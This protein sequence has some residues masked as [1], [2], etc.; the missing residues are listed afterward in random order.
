MSLTAEKIA[1]IVDQR[2]VSVRKTPRLDVVRPALFDDFESGLE[3][4]RH[5]ILITHSSIA[6][7]RAEYWLHQTFEQF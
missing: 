4:T 7:E 3:I 5:Q 1:P 2:F 6:K